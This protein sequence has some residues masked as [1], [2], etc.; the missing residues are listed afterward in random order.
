M[1][2]SRG[3]LDEPLRKLA[4]RA[5]VLLWVARLDRCCEYVNPCWLAFTGRSFEQGIGDGWVAR[6]HPSDLDRC[7]ATYHWAFET[8]EE[9]R[10]DFR[11]QRADETYWRVAEL[12]LARVDARGVFRGYLALCLQAGDC[13]EAEHVLKRTQVLHSAILGTIPGNVIFIAKGGQILTANEAWT[14]CAR[15]DG[16]DPN[17]VGIGANYRDAC[18][19]L[20]QKGDGVLPAALQGAEAVLRGRLD[21]FTLEYAAPSGDVE[22][23]FNLSIHPMRAP[24]RGAILAHLEVTRRHWAEAL[25]RGLARADSA[26][27]H[28]AFEHLIRCTNPAGEPSG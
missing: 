17:A 2:A 4:D 21:R 16:T 18:R 28:A 6:V 10:V 15:E 27:A 14:Q 11:L 23:W 25:A 7:L 8:R 1:S 22:R 5:P 20:L 26:Q 19:W 24:V 12:G 3:F 9:F 13:K